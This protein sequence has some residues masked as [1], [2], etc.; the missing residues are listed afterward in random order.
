[1]RATGARLRSDPRPKEPGDGSE[2]AGL[3][4][5]LDSKQVEYGRSRIK[6]VESTD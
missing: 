1:V 4:D 6:K 3:C 5:G 2:E